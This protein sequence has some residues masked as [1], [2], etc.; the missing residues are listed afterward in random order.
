[1]S[2]R[3]RSKYATLA[4]E[5]FVF[6]RSQTKNFSHLIMKYKLP[7]I[8]TWVIIWLLFHYFEFG[9]LWIIFT[10]FATIFLNLGER[11]AGELSAYSVFNEGFTKLL[12][13]ISPE[14]FEN[15]I[16]HGNI[17]PGQFDIA[18][19]S[20]D[21]EGGEGDRDI[22]QVNRVNNGRRNRANRRRRRNRFNAGPEDELLVDND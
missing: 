5:L 3:N 21:D 10:L 15:E 13:T 1:M 18:L 6:F 4:N 9:S 12:G 16:R 8:L 11:Q 2:N 20:S 22:R 7:H 14:Q 19:E 17:E